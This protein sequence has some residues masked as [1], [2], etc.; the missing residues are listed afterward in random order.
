MMQIILKFHFSFTEKLKNNMIENVL[1]FL[2]IGDI[3]CCTQVMFSLNAIQFVYKVRK[4]L[5]F[6]NTQAAG[7]HVIRL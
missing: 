6:Q 4:V 3:F 2:V 7:S 5:K 1:Y